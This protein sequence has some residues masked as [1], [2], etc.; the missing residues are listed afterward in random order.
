MMDSHR[1]ALSYFSLLSDADRATFEV[2]RHTLSS[3]ASRCC[4]NHRLAAFYEMLTAICGYCIRG[5]RD[6]GLRCLACGLCWLERGLI[7]INTRQLSHVLK[8]SKSSING[9][10]ALMRYAPMTPREQEVTKLCTAIPWLRGRAHDL[11]QWTMRSMNCPEAPPH[12]QPRVE[13]EDCHEE[14]LED[15]IIKLLTGQLCG[16]SGVV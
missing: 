6:D 14:K 9:S 12:E 13:W 4:R 16:R 1:E 3:P 15:Y 7:A 11:R 2:L 10:F 8:K 5:E